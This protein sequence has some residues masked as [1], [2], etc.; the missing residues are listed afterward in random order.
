MDPYFFLLYVNSFSK[1]VQ[2][3]KMHLFAYDKMFF[4][5]NE[6]VGKDLENIEKD[7]EKVT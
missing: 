4:G 3:S 6:N 7:L 5:E 2:N 1:A